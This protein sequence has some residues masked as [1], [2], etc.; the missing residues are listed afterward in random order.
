PLAALIC[1]A[2]A[3]VGVAPLRRA[4]VSRLRT[5]YRLFAAGIGVGVLGLLGSAAVGGVGAAVRLGPFAVGHAVSVVLL[6]AGLLRLRGAALR[7]ALDGALLAACALHITWTLFVEHAL[8]RHAGRAT[9]SLSD[10]RTFLLGV[11]L[12]VALA[13]VGIAGVTAG[14]AR[15]PRVALVLTGV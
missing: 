5:P 15:P 6:L 3:V 2:L 12:L 1:A 10:P 8:V 13:A 11:P 4:P 14:R 7:H 9:P